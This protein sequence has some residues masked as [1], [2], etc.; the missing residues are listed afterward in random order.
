LLELRTE[1]LE[2]MQVALVLLPELFQSAQKR[3]G[4]RL[5]SLTPDFQC[6]V[7]E[8]QVELELLFLVCALAGEVRRRLSRAAEGCG[9]IQH[10]VV[11]LLAL[12]IALLAAEALFFPSVLA[13]V[14]C[15]G[16]GTIV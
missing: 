14:A 15:H 4:G 1:G 11:L 9:A 3:L 12:P 5:R 7:Q 16:S 10:H 8:G 2:G 6:Q 13:L